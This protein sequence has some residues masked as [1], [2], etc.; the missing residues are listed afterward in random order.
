VT[1]AG[2]GP[3]GG[4][5]AVWVE[6]VS[7][8]L[9]LAVRSLARRRAFTA[10]TTGTF[11][12][13][14]GAATAAY[15]VLASVVLAPLPYE[16]PDELVRLYL[17]RPDHR[18]PD[19][20]VREFLSGP[21]LHAL[22]ADAGVFRELSA[23]YAYREM[24]GDWT[25]GD[26]PV[27]VSVLPASVGYFDLLGVAP[28]FGRTFASEDEGT[29]VVVLSHRAWSSAAANDPG[30]VGRTIHLD[31]VPHTVLGVMPAGFQGPLFDTDVWQLL[32]M[33]PAASWSRPGEWRNNNLGAVA[34]LLPG[35]D[36]PD[37]Q[38]RIDR[39]AAA[40][41]RDIAG[42]YGLGI[43]LVPLRDDL[44]GSADVTL[45]VVM[46]TAAFLL[47]V[48][49]VN[50]VNLFLARGLGRHQE[51]TVRRA[52]GAGRIDLLTLSAIEGVL[53]SV[54][55]G[56]AGLALAR[57][58]ILALP[59]IGSQGLPRMD[60]ISLDGG[61]I[62]FALSLM[63]CCALLFGAAPALPFLAPGAERTGRLDG[64][65]AGATRRH[66]AIGRSLIIAQLAASLVLL[67]GAGLTV[68][69]YRALRSVRLGM[70]PEGVVAFGVT[71][72][73]ARY[74][75]PQSR[76]ALHGDFLARVSALPGVR[77]AGATD[78]LPMHE[79]YHP[80]GYERLDLPDDHE[81]STRGIADVR[82]VTGDFFEAAGLAVVRGRPLRATDGTSGP[83]VAVVSEGALAQ[84]FGDTDPLG[85]RIGIRG[86]S[87]DIVGV[88]EDV[89]FD[90]R[91]RTV[92][93]VY[94]PH[95]QIADNRNWALT[96]LVSADGPTASIVAEA[97][98]ELA[99]FDPSLVLYRPHPL[100]QDFS[101]KVA[102]ER[103]AMLIIAG[104]AS[105]AF[106]LVIVGVYGVVSQVVD[107]RVREIGVRMAVG[108]GS[109]QTTRLVMG[110][111]MVLGGVGTAIGVAVA[112]ALTRGLRSILFEVGTLDPA[113]FTVVSLITLLT[114]AL[115]GAA[116]AR[117]ASRVDP[118]IA[119]RADAAG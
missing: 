28:A 48:A 53:V 22:R 88:V 60:E 92:P 30:I 35:V 37:A 94:L 16:A 64:V 15:A 32:D 77:A 83:S 58:V 74:A 108:A 38:A 102:R 18:Q 25:D 70:N 49:C 106:V 52:L 39:F 36:L 27:R 71:L 85:M 5:E 73:D 98:A 89:P 95:D 117:R 56:S 6:A 80:W 1:A 59:R 101:T 75:T 111:V 72:P 63:V 84:R 67:V 113:V 3:L 26:V 91:G 57:C 13:A 50:V 7:R 69:S 51:L 104:F 9:R 78:W 79:R 99:A 87:F 33:R 19:L 47:L 46:A 54:I 2:G 24:G 43:R 66:R 93:V 41:P 65:R 68:K 82:V 114:T 109:K 4:R 12:L 107:G 8:H 116:P 11:A 20:R 62:L 81:G 55:G 17:H 10:V 31:G 34:R 96:Y 76:V 103:L 45:W 14:L 110:E 86:R 97:R 21:Y 42:P 40:L 105:I 29:D 118:A 112:V 23:V 61:V 90:A 115:A 119:L 100:D 44:L